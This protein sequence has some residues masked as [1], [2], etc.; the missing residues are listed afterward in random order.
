LPPKPLYL[1]Q[2][3]PRSPLAAALQGIASITDEGIWMALRDPKLMLRTRQ[4]MARMETDFQNLMRAGRT[5]VSMVEL[6]MVRELL[7][8]YESR[9]SAEIRGV[10]GPIRQQLESPSGRQNLGV[11]VED[12]FQGLD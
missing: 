12:R 10:L 5:Q 9:G 1:S 2:Q 11:L 6:Q 8:E 7:V 3:E 4:L